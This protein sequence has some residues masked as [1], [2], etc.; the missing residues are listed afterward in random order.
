M[1]LAD[2]AR[3]DVAT[4][5]RRNADAPDATWLFL[6]IPK[7]A[8]SSFRSE[9]ARRLKPEANITVNYA[10]DSRS[11]NEKLQAAVE[12]FCAAQASAPVRFASGHLSRGLM[13]EIE[14]GVVNPRLVTMLRDPV[15]RVVSDYRYQR[16]PAHPPHRS[17]IERYPRFEAYLESRES[18][19][20]MTAF[21][22]RDPQQ[23]VDDIVADINRSF[24][25]VGITELYT[26]SFRLLTALLG[27]VA[28]PALHERRT[29]SNDD[30]QIPNLE[31]LRPRIAE[32]NRFDMAIYQHFRRRLER[33]RT[34]IDTELTG[35][36][37]AAM[38][39]EA[40]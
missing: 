1:S 21:L 32:L 2:L 33:Q 22:R 15:A 37:S 19:N 25:F 5:L 18:Q 20:K 3:G 8:G 30:N 16:T 26:L 10:D 40:R 34:A 24:A 35:L 7:T 23:S 27:A 4:Y 38:A 28:A 11:H 29:D 39:A 6:H 36:E 12:A 17:F 13:A 31:A 14:A 9:L